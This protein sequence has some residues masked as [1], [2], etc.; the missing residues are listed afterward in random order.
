M[1]VG[2]L[3]LGGETSNIFYVHPETWGNDPIWLIFF[4]W[5]GEPTT[6]QNTCFFCNSCEVWGLQIVLRTSDKKTPQ[7]FPKIVGFPQIIHFFRIF[8]HKPSILGYPIFGSTPISSPKNMRNN[9]IPGVWKLGHPAWPSAIWNLSFFFRLF[10]LASIFFGRL[11]FL[12]TAQKFGASNLWGPTFVKCQ[13]FGYP[14]R[15][16]KIGQNS[17][18]DSPGFD[19]GNGFTLSQHQVAVGNSTLDPTM[20][21]EGRKIA[22]GSWGESERLLRSE[23][24]N[25][26]GG[27][28]YYIHY[29]LTAH[30]PR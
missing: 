9:P 11:K 20:A 25:W 29:P 12:G 1:V 18:F 27:R 26:G 19:S 16:K 5:V 21:G 22:R 28:S 10:L 17:P 6:N 4:K 30:P 3:K 14:I 8:H 15:P 24:K 2:T 7:R 23:K 13:L